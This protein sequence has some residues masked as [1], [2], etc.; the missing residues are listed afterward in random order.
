M[1]SRPEGASFSFSLF[2]VLFSTIDSLRGLVSEEDF[3]EEG[4][5]GAGL[6]LV[7][8]SFSSYALI[9]PVHRTFHNRVAETSFE[10]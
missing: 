1:D 3:A 5:H 6:K 8:L 4:L 10:L 2:I 7:V 9:Y